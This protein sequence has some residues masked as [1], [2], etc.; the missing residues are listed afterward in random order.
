MWIKFVAVNLKVWLYG[1]L[2]FHFPQES[3]SLGLIGMIIDNS[4]FHSQKCPS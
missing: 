3:S 4:P 1:N 2:M